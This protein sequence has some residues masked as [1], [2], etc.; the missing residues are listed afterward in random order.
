MKKYA[1]VI[2]E[3]ACW[4]CKTCEVAC[5]QEQ[6]TPGGISYISVSEDGPRMVD[7]KLDFTYRVTVCKHCENPPCRDVCPVDAIIQRD[8]GIVILQSDKCTGCEAC[9]EACPYHAIS[10]DPE[11]KVAR[12]CNLCY[13]RIDHGLY[14]ACADNVCPAHCI[15]FGDAT[16]IDTMIEKKEWLTYRIE[17]KLGS[18]VV[19]IDD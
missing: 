12:K 8:D 14:P 15:Y 18:W 6:N 1:L 19:H 5:K 13:F 10:F 9:I 4:G 16:T 7:G 2:K 11:Q 3:D 17:G